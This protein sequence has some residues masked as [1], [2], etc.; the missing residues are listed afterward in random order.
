MKCGGPDPERSRTRQGKRNGR[1]ERLEAE[2]RNRDEC[3]RDRKTSDGAAP[4]VVKWSGGLGKSTQ[5]EKGVSD[6]TRIGVFI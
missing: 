5:T 1:N 2:S 3:V 4:F 6:K